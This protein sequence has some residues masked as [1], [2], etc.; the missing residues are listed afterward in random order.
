MK[1]RSEAPAVAA[2]LKLLEFLA[3]RDGEWGPSA[4]ARELAITPNLTYRILSELLREGYVQRNDAGRYRLSEKLFVLGMKLQD[5]FDLVKCARPVL[6]ELSRNTGMTA[7][8]Q[9]PGPERMVVLDFVV[10]PVD[11]YMAVRPGSQVYF[12]GNAFGKAVLPF[13]DD[14]RRERILAAP[15]EPLTE[16]TVVDPE[17]LRRELDVA[18]SSR[19]A[20]EFNEYLQG[21]Y[22]IASPVFDARGEAV[23]AIGVTGLFSLFRPER[24]PELQTLVRE[25]AGALS[26]RIGNQN[27]YEE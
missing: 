12:H 7:Q 2:L 21:N 10:P 11:Y 4:L 23:A 15:L 16:A 18:K 25:S 1:E 22:C 20:T 17:A 26:V 3:E 27:A 6:E 13:F 24:L 9:I 5:R 8:M 19:V 14:E